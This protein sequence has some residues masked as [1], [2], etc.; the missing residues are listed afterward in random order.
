MDNSRLELIQIFKGIFAESRQVT[1]VDNI[2]EQLLT[3]HRLRNSEIYVTNMYEDLVN[4][5]TIENTDEFY[6]HE[7]LY[8]GALYFLNEFALGN[9]MS[10]RKSSDYIPNEIIECCK[11]IKM[12]ITGSLI[13]FFHSQINAINTLESQ[14][15]QNEAWIKR[16]IYFEFILSILPH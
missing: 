6:Y 7:I 8:I 10:H 1:F 15:R 14:E 2:Q 16:K 13:S 9:G 12:D 4:D 11:N 3:F 5:K